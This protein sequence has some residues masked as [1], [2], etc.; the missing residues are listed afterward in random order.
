MFREGMGA[1]YEPRIL[2][3]SFLCY[4]GLLEYLKIRN[5]TKWQTYKSD[6]NQ[7]PWIKLHRR[8]LRNLEWASLSDAERGQLV[9]IWILAADKDGTIPSDPEIVKGLCFMTDAP[10]INKFIELGFISPNGPSVDSKL[11]PR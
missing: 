4:E 10:N 8:V 5:W 6:R 11:E 1:G 9:C 2:S 7:P 3:G